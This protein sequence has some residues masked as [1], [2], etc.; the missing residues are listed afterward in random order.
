MALSKS[1]DTKARGGRNIG[2][3]VKAGVIIYAGALTAISP[4]KLN[5]A[6]FCTLTNQMT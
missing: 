5:A 1:R 6:S 2:L 3:A 4:L